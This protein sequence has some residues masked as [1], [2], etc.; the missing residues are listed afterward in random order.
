VN[1]YLLRPSAEADLQDIWRYT[2]TNWSVA[3]ADRYYREIVRAFDA[4]TAQP[5][6]GRVCDEVKLGYRKHGVAAH[7]IFYRVTGDNVDVVRILHA[8]RD[9]R[10]HLPSS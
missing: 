2:A 6:I 3:Q 4:I 5:T 9:F 10:R 8:R 7:V 1:T